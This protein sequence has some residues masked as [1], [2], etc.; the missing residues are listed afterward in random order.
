V[1]DRRTYSI[2][3]EQFDAISRRAAEIAIPL[4]TDILRQMVLVEMSK[5]REETN[6]HRAN[7]LLQAIG[8]ISLKGSF[9]V[10]WVVIASIA[11]GVI[12]AVATWFQIRNHP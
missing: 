9:K 5:L 7:D 11:S 8:E 10:L 3:Q 12:G 4:A 6:S 2:P 1:D